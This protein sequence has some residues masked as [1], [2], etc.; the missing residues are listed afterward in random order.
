MAQWNQ[1][2]NSLATENGC[3]LKINMWSEIIP[4]YTFAWWCNG[5]RRRSAPNSAVGQ[6]LSVQVAEWCSRHFLL[7]FNFFYVVSKNFSSAFQN[8][9]CFCF[10]TNP[11]WL[12]DENKFT[13]INKCRLNF[14][15]LQTYGQA[16]KKQ[17]K[18]NFTPKSNAT[19]IIEQ[20]FTDSA[21]C[22]ASLCLSLEK[23]RPATPGIKMSK[24]LKTTDR[25]TQQVINKRRDIFSGVYW[26]NSKTYLWFFLVSS[27]SLNFAIS[28]RN[29]SLRHIRM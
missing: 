2:F 19:T 6:Y 1:L 29:F 18:V 3:E 4:N 9:F 11:R 28:K 13:A 26:A 24:I 7:V 5:C 25:T 14:C 23:G 27:Y 8:C 22:A 15:H 17:E 20:V 21:F 10:R 16:K 12:T